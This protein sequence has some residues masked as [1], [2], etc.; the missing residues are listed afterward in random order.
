MIMASISDKY[1]CQR[2][3]NYNY[4]NFGNHISSISEILFPASRELIIGK[5]VGNI[6]ATKKI[7]A[8]I[9]E[10]VV[11]HLMLYMCHYVYIY[12]CFNYCLGWFRRSAATLA[13]PSE[14]RGGRDNGHSQPSF[15]SSCS[16]TLR[17]LDEAKA[18]L[19][20]ELMGSL[21]DTSLALE[22]C[23]SRLDDSPNWTPCLLDFRLD[24]ETTNIELEASL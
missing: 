3:W 23:W 11:R 10:L 14:F 6:V 4:Q 9:F 16:R 1:S 20:S 19:G 13:F 5:L 17:I 24:K 22:W 7:S 15:G 18:R 2:F 21:A 12:I 8:G